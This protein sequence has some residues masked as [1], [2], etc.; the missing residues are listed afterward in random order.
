[1]YVAHTNNTKPWLVSLTT[2]DIFVDKILVIRSLYNLVSTT[3]NRMAVSVKSRTWGEAIVAYFKTHVAFALR[4]TSGTR[5]VMVVSYRR[6]GTTRRSHLQGSS[7]P[8]RLPGTLRYAVIQEWCTPLSR[9][10]GN[11]HFTLRKVPEEQRSHSHRGG[12]LKLRRVKPT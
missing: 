5:R 12:S 3:E 2:K 1:V 6:F 9:N 10:V 8:R 7:S 4:R 11:Y